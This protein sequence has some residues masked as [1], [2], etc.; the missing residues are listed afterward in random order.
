MR[1]AW[2][3]PCVTELQ[4]G[5][6][7]LL[8]QS[9]RTD[10]TLCAGFGSPADSDHLFGISLKNISV[11]QLHSS[12]ML[13]AGLL[14]FCS[15]FLADHLCRRTSMARWAAVSMHD[16]HAI[17]LTGAAALQGLLSCLRVW[18]L[19]HR[20]DKPVCAS[21]LQQKAFLPVNGA[22]C[23]SWPPAPH[24]GT[25]RFCEIWIRPRRAPLLHC[26]FWGGSSVTV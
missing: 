15:Q 22:L 13:S 7:A 11:A 25:R 10:S 18:S 16:L 6:A 12:F 2:L 5:T 20:A 8:H 24:F 21:L 19:L 4:G 3:Q 17:C 26:C 9:H 1:G 14:F 23:C